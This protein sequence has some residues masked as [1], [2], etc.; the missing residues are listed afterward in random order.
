MPARR[1][2]N[3]FRRQ[4][5]QQRLTSARQAELLSCSAAFVKKLVSESW[6]TVSPSLALQFEVRSGG[7]VRFMDIMRWSYDRLR[8][9]PVRDAA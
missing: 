4:K 3:P 7:A 9:G 8:H 5:R 1:P 2:A 6:V